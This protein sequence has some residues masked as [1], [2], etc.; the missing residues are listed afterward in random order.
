MDRIENIPSS[1]SIVTSRIYRHGQRREHWFPVNLLR[2]TILLPSN[3][4]LCW[5]NSSCLEQI[6]HNIASS[7]LLPS[8]LVQPEFFWLVFGRRVLRISV[9]T[10]STLT[11]S[12]FT[13]EAPSKWRDSALNLPRA[14]SSKSYPI[15]SVFTIN[16]QLDA[17]QWKLLVT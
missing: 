7:P 14:R 8:E 5:L 11:F 3:G 2:V 15:I 9:G 13:S 17:A 16:Q 10:S 12:S 1:T 4:C 6:W